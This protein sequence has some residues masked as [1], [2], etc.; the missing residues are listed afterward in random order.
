MNKKRVCFVTTIPMTIDWFVT[1]FGKEFVKRGYDVFYITSNLNDDFIKRHEYAT[2]IEVPMA[3]GFNPLKLIMG[4]R[5]MQKTLKDY[6]FESVFYG[7]PNAS[8]ITSHAAKKANIEKRIYLQWGYRYIGF[9]NPLLYHLSKWI[10]KSTFKK[11][12]HSVIV[13]KMNRDIAIKEGFCTEDNSGVAG[14]GGVAGADTNVINKLLNANNKSLIKE[15]YHIPANMFVFGFTGRICT[16]KGLN[17]LI[18]AFELLKKNQP[19]LSVCLVLQGPNDVQ[20]KETR[21]ILLNARTDKDIIFIEGLEHSEALRVMSTFDVL[22]HPTYRDGF[23]TTIEEAMAFGIPCITTNIPGPSEVLQNEVNGLLVEVKNVS[24]LSKAMERYLLN[25]QIRN[26]HSKKA[27]EY[28][29]EHYGIEK[30]TKEYV[31]YLEKLVVR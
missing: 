4:I 18:K 14:V 8:F 19:Q 1:P 23:G 30:C 20:T 15:E 5:S 10:E 21:R 17:E 31:D 25:N 2:C 6:K 13:S 28:A 9:K 24:A 27:Y 16:D 22:V 29:T 11:S 3:R 7:T 12:T 26:E